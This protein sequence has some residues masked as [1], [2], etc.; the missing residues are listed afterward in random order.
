MESDGDLQKNIN[1]RG[2]LERLLKGAFSF[3]MFYN[4]LTI[5]PSQ[6]GIAATCF[7]QDFIRE[8]IA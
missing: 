6:G 7:D 5:S 3:L 4:F 2:Y 8:D 1:E